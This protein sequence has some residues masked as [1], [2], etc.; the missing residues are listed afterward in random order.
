MFSSGWCS[1]ARADR[2]LI[3]GR[4]MDYDDAPG[5]S[6]WSSLQASG[7]SHLPRLSLFT[8]HGAF[9]KPQILPVCSYAKFTR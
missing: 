3:S 5:F 6:W 1:S 9:T 4:V 7:T 8:E 2:M